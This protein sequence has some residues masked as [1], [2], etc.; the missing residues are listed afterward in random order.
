M[1]KD[2]HGGLYAAG[3]PQP[4]GLSESAVSRQIGDFLNRTRVFHLRTNSGKIKV[5]KN[6]V[7]LCPEGTPDRF[8][9]YRGLFLPVEVKRDE[10]EK[11]SLVQQAMHE[12]IERE[13]GQKTIVAWTVE[14]VAERL[15]E[16][17]WL[18]FK[19]EWGKLLRLPG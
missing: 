7:H 10:K 19:G 15:R 2:F 4:L 12:R 18:I 1:N 8:I 14:Q 11:P 13:G 6:W 5:G 17:D 3:G 16:I 9:F